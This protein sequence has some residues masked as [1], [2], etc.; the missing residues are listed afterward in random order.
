MQHLESLLRNEFNTVDDTVPP[1]AAIDLID[2]TRRTR[3]RRRILT[4]SSAAIAVVAVV[5]IV[6]SPL[7]GTSFTEPAH[8]FP[9]PVVP[10]DSYPDVASKL[11]AAGSHGIAIGGR[12]LDSRHGVLEVESCQPPRAVTSPPACVTSLSVTG[13]GGTT[14]TSR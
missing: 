1:P 8:R 7:N 2:N 13:D 3:R 4:Q 9:Q 10:I 5:A 6:T 14:F 12:F 11:T